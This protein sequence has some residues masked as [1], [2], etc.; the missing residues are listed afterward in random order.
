MREN[1]TLRSTHLYAS[2]MA[3]LS[4]QLQVSLTHNSTEKLHKRYNI[5]VCHQNRFGGVVGYHVSLTEPFTGLRTLKVPSSNL[6]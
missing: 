6:G 5:D 2:E 1:Q 3:I 4:F